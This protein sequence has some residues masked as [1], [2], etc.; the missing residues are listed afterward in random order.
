MNAIIGFL[1]NGATTLGGAGLAVTLGEAVA[2][3]TGL[4][5]KET[6]IVVEGVDFLCDVIGVPQPE[7]HQAPQ[8]AGAQTTRRI[9]ISCAP[10]KPVVIAGAGETV[11]IDLGL[12]DDCAVARMDNVGEIEALYEGW[13]D[14]YGV[15]GLDVGKVA[16]C[17]V[18]PAKSDKK[19]DRWNGFDAEAFYKA[20]SK[21]QKCVAREKA[22]NV[23][24][25]KAEVKKINAEK[26][27]TAEAQKKVAKHALA[28]QK[29]KYEASIAEMQKAQ[30]DAKTT[31]EKT[32]Y[33]QQ[34]DR[35]NAEALNTSRLQAEMAS[36][37]NDAATQAKIDQLQATIA[38]NAAKPGGMDAMMSKMLEMQMMKT[39][40]APP[41]AAADPMA[42]MMKI[43]AM[44]SMFPAQ[45]PAPA[46]APQ[47]L[48]APPMFQPPQMQMQPMY[49]QG[50][51]QPMYDDGGGMPGYYY[52][53]AD[54]GEPVD[55]DI[56]DAFGLSGVPGLSVGDANFLTAVRDAGQLDFSALITDLGSVDD[57]DAR[58]PGNCST[59]SC[60]L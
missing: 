56:A 54:A 2:K 17:G 10:E 13:A 53:G 58:M 27:K 18:K 9:C 28:N 8:L 14:S 5:R 21:W 23:S 52:Q 12:C 19:F 37:A 46:P 31:E 47:Q 34:I 24:E 50:I 59:G 41:P 51:P 11:E 3:R 36:K 1:V 7:V 49:D 55:A 45:P 40:M 33:Q 60:G 44:A 42:E 22:E 15:A 48:Q 43:K 20:L 26:K 29:A 30:A 38:N 35:L 25:H 16:D 6:S 4:M 57:D 32:Q 39:M